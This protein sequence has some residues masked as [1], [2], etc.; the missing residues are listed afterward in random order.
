VTIHVL[1]SPIPIVE[2]QTSDPVAPAYEPPVTQDEF[3]DYLTGNQD[4]YQYIASHS[5]TSSADN[6]SQSDDSR[7][8]ATEP[9]QSPVVNKQHKVTEVQSI[10]KLDNPDYIHP[11]IRTAIAPQSLDD[12]ADYDKYMLGKALRDALNL[13][14]KEI[15]ESLAN[16]AEQEHIF[17]AGIQG[18]S[19]VLTAGF[20]TWALRGSS[21]LAS[22]LS[23]IP[24]WRGLDPLPILAAA[25]NRPK[26]V[27]N[28]AEQ[29][30]HNA[31]DE[32]DNIFDHEDINGPAQKDTE[33][34]HD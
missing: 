18:S 31:N 14:N 27:I 9:K 12:N 8:E 22:F 10:A 32:I 1:A 25:K 17:T 13:M 23:T 3:T 16:E 24:V 26:Q 15:D 19:I 33:D 4:D 6:S 5:Q 34:K 11:S 2:S 21:L 28:I 30:Q 29:H 20:A 7:S